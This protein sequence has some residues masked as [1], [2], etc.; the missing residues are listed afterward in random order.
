MNNCVNYSLYVIRNFRLIWHMCSKRPTFSIN[1]NTG[2]CLEFQVQLT[3]SNRQNIEKVPK[4]R[5]H[6]SG[7]S[8]FISVYIFSIRAVLLIVYQV[9]RLIPIVT[10]N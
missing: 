10:K 2:N 4:L 5:V 3:K 9:L 6:H 7:R 8:R 1:E